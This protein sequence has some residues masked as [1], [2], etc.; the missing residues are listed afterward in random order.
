MPV[1]Y[2]DE[3]KARAVELV[4]HAQADPET[5]SGAITRVANELGLSKETLRVWVRKHKDSGRATPTESVDLEAENRRLRAEL[6]EAKR[7][8]EILR[9]ASL[10]SNRQGN[11]SGFRVVRSCWAS[12]GVRKLKHFRGR[13]LSS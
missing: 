12:S 11:T 3:L 6:T 7:A 10:D 4:M 2:T 8:N 5:A 1:K 13:V 9:R